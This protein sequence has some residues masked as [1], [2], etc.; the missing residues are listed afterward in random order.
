M[1]ALLA[2]ASRART[3]YRAAALA[4]LETA[5]GGFPGDHYTAAAPQLLQAVAR[6][7]A[8]P[9]TPAALPEP[10]VR[11]SGQICLMSRGLAM[12]QA[13]KSCVLELGSMGMSRRGARQA[14]YPVHRHNGFLCKPVYC[15][16]RL[17]CCLLRTCSLPRGLC[18]YVIMKLCFR[19]CSGCA[20]AMELSLCCCAFICCIVHTPAPRHARCCLLV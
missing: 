1:G 5:L 20:G 12:D 4:A 17:Q 3:V 8:S 19:L 14:L 15:W 11:G 9:G 18:I 16:S 6:H 10:Q 2:A 13:Q 7:A